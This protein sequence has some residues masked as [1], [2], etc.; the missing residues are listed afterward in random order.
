[1][2]SLSNESLSCALEGR[3]DWPVEGEMLSR[4]L[5][6]AIIAFSSSEGTLVSASVRND[7]PL[8][9]LVP[10]SSSDSPPFPPVRGGRVRTEG[11]KVSVFGGG[12]RRWAVG[13]SR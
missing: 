4:S 13:V 7:Y 5:L 1:M 3:F 12:G 8:F 10:M 9:L 11:R 2:W 6:W